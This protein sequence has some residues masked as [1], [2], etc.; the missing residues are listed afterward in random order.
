MLFDHGQKRE[1]SE[2][3][4]PSSESGSPKSGKSPRSERQENISPKGE[5][6]FYLKLVSFREELTGT[7]SSL[8][9]FYKRKN[10]RKKAHP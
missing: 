5:P 3:S 1:E 10:K 7:S 2:R 8:P 9:F 6:H 4:I